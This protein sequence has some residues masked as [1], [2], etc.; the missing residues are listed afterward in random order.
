[1]HCIQWLKI[2]FWGA[3]YSL[4]WIMCL[5]IFK[6]LLYAWCCNWVLISYFDVTINRLS[7]W[8]KPIVRKLLLFIS[9]KLLLSS[10]PFWGQKEIFG[11][12]LAIL[13]FVGD[14][15]KCFSLIH[16]H[17]SFVTVQWNL[18]QG[19]FQD[20]VWFQNHSLSFFI[21]LFSFDLFSKELLS[22]KG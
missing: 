16:E 20:C 8:L 6:F 13:F 17:F 5:M 11:F 15:V 14:E 10:L 9:L 4:L 3:C 2:G 22:F 18:G 21:I 1:M 7:W 12:R 19:C